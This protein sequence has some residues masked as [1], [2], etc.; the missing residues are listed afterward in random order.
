MMRRANPWLICAGWMSVVAAVAHIACIFGGP[1]WYIFMGAPRRFAYAAG[2]GEIM[3][4]VTTLAIAG[5]LLIWSAF[6]FSA[7][8]VLRRLPLCR[9]ALILI[10]AVLLIRGVGYFILP[11]AKL[12]RPDLSLTFMLWSSAICVVMGACFALGTWRAWPKISQ[13]T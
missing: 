7:A 13:R 6:A 11:N 8:D 5:M 3:P 10:S 2:R 12:W 4:V 1:E 9:L